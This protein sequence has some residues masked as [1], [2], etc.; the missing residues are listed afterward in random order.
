MSKKF[1]V[2]AG[3]GGYLLPADGRCKEVRPLS[4]SP[5]T[6]IRY[7]KG[8]GEKR[9]ALYH[10]LEIHTIQDLLYHF[11][12]SY[13]DLTHPQEIAQAP[14]GQEVVLRARVVQKSREQRIRKGLSIF[15]VLVSDDSAEA[16]LTFFNA[17]YTVEALQVEQ[18]YLF[19]G[20]L[21]GTLLHK[22]VSAPAV[23]DASLTGLLPI[24]PLTA[25]LSTRMISQNVR[26]A[27]ELLG[28]QFQEFLPQDLLD[29]YRLCSLGEAL[30]WIHFPPSAA[31]AQRARERLLF[32]ELFLLS[33][34]LRSLKEERQV[35]HGIPLPPV[36]LSPLLQSLPYR[37]T[38]A[39]SRTIRQAMADMG[40][41]R[42]MN[43]LVQGDVGSGKTLVAC[44][45][46]YGAVQGGYQAALMAPTEI[47]AEQHYHNLSAQLEPLGVHCGLLTGS[48][49]AAQKR[50]VHR[51]L[52]QGEIDFCIGTHAL[53]S[54]GVA[55]H[56]LALVITDEQHRF[57]VAQRMAL[58]QK[59][60]NPHMLI[61][62][63][64]PIPRT[65][66]LVMYADL[67]IS[68]IDELPPGRTPVGT[69]LIDSSKRRR[70]YGFVQKH[71]DA[72]RQAYMVCPLVEQGEEETP[73]KT[74]TEYAAQL[75]N[76]PF[77][78]YRVGLL[79]GR[80]KPREKEQVMRAFQRGEIQLLVATTVIEVGV[81]VPNAVIM[82]I[83]NAERFGLSQLHQLRGRVGRGSNQ[84]HCILISD[85][86]AP[87][88]LSRL[89]M[90][91]STND[92]FQISQFD[93]AHRGPGDFFGTRQHGLPQLKLANLS[94]DLQQVEL[95]QQE[96]LQL[97]QE[98]PE[99]SHPQHQALKG[100]MLQMLDGVGGL[101]N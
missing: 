33:L 71:L 25:G 46:A 54:Q 89:K 32:E 70:A 99:L 16:L 59:G 15:R 90:L 57:G 80:M 58:S 56:R 64:T 20:T 69:Y 92:G 27:L 85:S 5:Q 22:E 87:E 61:L 24:Y 45:C 4:I 18:E 68:V 53:L 63:A 93:L 2:T 31:Q 21:S 40:R 67:D 82:L 1:E 9:A 11:P 81:D 49:T 35:A 17:K 88:T 95:A 47:L 73:L 91:C 51:Q 37:P 36:D 60:C 44:A 41:D 3:S 34:G 78:R 97:L 72:G 84:S 42:P 83:E 52:A 100:R 74:A 66:A 30:Q 75:Q 29:R 76:G 65:L 14:L 39:Q 94:S 86:K 13:V 55:F 96:A 79:H 98:D 19:H 8:V 38:G 12:R 28:G 7:L 62:S 23:Y 77:A 48:L 26:Q 10:K 101:P 6:D 50:E 43:R